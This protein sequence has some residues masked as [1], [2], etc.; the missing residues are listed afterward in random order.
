[1]YNRKKQQGTI[2][3]E[4]TLITFALV[5]ALFVPFDGDKSAAVKFMEAVRD[6]HSNSSYVLSLP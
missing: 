5:F 4:W 2:S 1:M 6:F 3:I